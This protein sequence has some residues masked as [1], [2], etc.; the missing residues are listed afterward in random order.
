MCTEGAGGG[1]KVH[2]SGCLSWGSARTRAEVF[3]IWH[4]LELEADSNYNSNTG[5]HFDCDC[6]YD[7]DNKN[8]N[9]Y[10]INNYK[11]ENKSLLSIFQLKRR[12][13]L[14]AW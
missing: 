8:K 6:D 12:R 2:S 9:N 13:N 14:H 11:S 4:S 5:S 3:A 7:N 10:N 1:S